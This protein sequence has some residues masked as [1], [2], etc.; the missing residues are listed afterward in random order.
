MGIQFLSKTNFPFKIYDKKLVFC[1]EWAASF[2]AMHKGKK[3]FL[4]QSVRSSFA[5]L[6]AHVL[7]VV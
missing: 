4:F 2:L 7:L 6:F 5:K 3:P 1:E